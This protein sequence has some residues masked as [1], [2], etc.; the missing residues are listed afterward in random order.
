MAVQGRI[1]V[2]HEDVFPQPTLLLSVSAVENF[3]KARAAR[4]A[5]R[6]DADV[7]D[8]DRDTGMRL[9]TAS[10]LDPT[11]PEGRREIKVKIA[12][13]QQPVPPTGVMTPVEFDGLQVIPYVDTNRTRP[14]LGIA[15]RASGFRGAPRKSA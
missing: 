9:W 13:E 11:A 10:I 7:Q 8:R 1:N 5:G 15:Y 4:E 3:D 12:S 6:K 14:R 2:R